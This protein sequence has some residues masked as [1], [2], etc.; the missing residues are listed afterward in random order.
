[1]LLRVNFYI[2]CYVNKWHGENELRWELAPSLC[3]PL[4]FHLC[5]FGTPRWFLTVQLWWRQ[6]TC[7]QYNSQY[8]QLLCWESRTLPLSALSS[9]LNTA[10]RV[11][12]RFL[13]TL[14][15]CMYT[16][17]QPVSRH[18]KIR[19]A[20]ILAVSQREPACPT[21][22]IFNR[23]VTMPFAKCFVQ[24]QCDSSSPS[25]ENPSCLFRAISGRS[26]SANTSTNQSR[27]WCDTYLLANGRRL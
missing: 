19:E 12:C 9:S 18:A 21:I 3:F 5:S 8:K 13:N 22:N 24:I 1:M 25:D 4:T 27:L 16:D 6:L 11:L 17:T 15:T 2:S 26:G 23:N 7:I 14:R 10:I 20:K